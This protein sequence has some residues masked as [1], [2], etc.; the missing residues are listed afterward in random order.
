MSKLKIIIISVA[1]VIFLYLSVCTTDFLLVTN[2]GKPLFC[3]KDAENNYN[4]LGY[5]Y[6]IYDHPI[7]GKSEYAIY[8]LG[9]SVYNN[10]TN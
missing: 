3:I 1:I 6:V 5:S 10:F 7:T 9:N 2:G 4:G 8:V